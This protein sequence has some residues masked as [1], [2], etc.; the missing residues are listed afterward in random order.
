MA[1]GTPKNDSVAETPQITT[2]ADASTNGLPAQTEALQRDVVMSD[3]PADQPA[4]SPAPVA[5]APSP[6][7]ARTGTPAQGS[8]AASA[9]PDAGLTIPAEAI[10]HGDSA[11]RYLNTKVTGVLLEGMKQLAKDQPSDPLRVLGEYLIQKSKE[12]EGTG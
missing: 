7:P 1:D 11:R 6:A 9:H 8:R 4:S 5:H 10:P 3:A 2:S 12:L